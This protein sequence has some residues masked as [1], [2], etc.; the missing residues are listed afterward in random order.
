MVLQSRREARF[1]ATCRTATSSTSAEVEAELARIGHDFAPVRHRPWSTL[2]PGRDYGKPD[3]L[4]KRLRHGPR[5]DPSGCWS[6]A[7][8][9]P[10]PMR[11]AGMRRSFIRRR[12][13]RTRK[14]RQHHLGRPP[15]RQ[16]DPLLPHREAPPISSSFRRRATRS[17]ASRSRSRAP[18]RASPAR[19]RS[20]TA[21]HVARQADR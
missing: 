4:A 15:G 18:R 13:S 11:G 8:G 19:W 20:S 16:R 12:N 5:G 1:P 9:L 3:Y 6:A 7:S 10:A 14:I 21:D 2:L 17:P